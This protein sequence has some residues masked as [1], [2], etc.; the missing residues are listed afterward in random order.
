MLVE[1]VGAKRMVGGGIAI[2][3]PATA[4]TALTSS[5]ASILA[6]SGHGW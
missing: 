3:S 4:L 1:R 2:L 5:F 6:A